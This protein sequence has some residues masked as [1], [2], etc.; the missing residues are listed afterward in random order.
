MRHERP[1]GGQVTFT[2][3]IPAY[4]A[5]ATIGAALHSV[6]SQTR[7]DFEIVVVDDGST[8]DTYKRVA[9]FLEDGRV[10]LVRQ[11]NRGLAGARN[12]AITQGRGR[13][14]SLLDGD[15]VWAPRYLETMAAALEADPGAAFAHGRA[16]IL[17]DRTRRIRRA[18]AMAYQHPPAT[19]PPDG[20][21]LLIELLERHNFI[22]G[23]VTLRRQAIDAVGPFNSSLRAAEDFEMWLRLAARGHHAVHVPEFVALYRQRAGSLSRDVAL[24]TAALAEV[25][26]LVAEEWEVPEEAR[27]IARARLAD[28]QVALGAATGARPVAGL[29]MRS[30]RAAARLK[31]R[32]LREKLW[33]PSPPGEVTAVFPDLHTL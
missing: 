7:R 19:A 21:T 2:V 22:F 1:D 20:E 24:M 3:V 14:I 30:R 8:D 4:N 5:A 32:L 16:W 18:P 6:L 11:E 28:M 9:P 10:V 15:D 17:D 26:R 29:V 27:V 12:T 13:Y 23:L 25:F 31:Q 33:Y